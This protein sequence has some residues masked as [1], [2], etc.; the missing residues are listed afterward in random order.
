M[1]RQTPLFSAV[2]RPI[3]LKCCVLFT[4]PYVK[5]S[6]KFQSIRSTD[7][8]PGK[9]VSDAT[10][11]GRKHKPKFNIFDT[12]PALQSP[13]DGRREQCREVGTLV[14]GVPLTTNKLSATNPRR[15]NMRQ[16]SPLK[17]THYI[18]RKLFRGGIGRGRAILWEK[19]S[20]T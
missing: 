12:I 17:T 20:D 2:C 1:L 3:K 9:G 8:R 4:T 13:Q 7:D 6:P 11:E 10:F 19:E 15:K 5:S 14:V 18:P 16:F